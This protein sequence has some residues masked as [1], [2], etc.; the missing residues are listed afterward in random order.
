MSRI[1]AGT[2]GGRRIRTP[3]GTTTRPTSDRVREALF[4]RAESLLGG[5][6][7]LDGLAV[8]DLYAGSGAV[9]LEALSRG[10]ASAVLVESDRQA[11]AVLHANIA[12]LGVGS[13]ARVLPRRVERVLADTAPAPA[14]L[15]FADP[16]YETGATA[17][18][19]AL[20]T[21]ERAGWLAAGAVVVVERSC[22]DDWEFPAGIALDGERRYGDTSLWYGHV[23]PSMT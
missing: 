15:V 8:L 12:L 4:A 5:P 6:G 7:G 2:L 9:G 20:A 17:L 11:V 22:R 23:D 13:R 14:D 3:A 16:P 18:R 21:G 19:H 1:V 10:A